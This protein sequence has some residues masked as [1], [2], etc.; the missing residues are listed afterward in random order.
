MKRPT[1]I[2]IGRVVLPAQMRGQD[3]AFEAALRDALAGHGT[4]DGDAP[5]RAAQS[6]ADAIAARSAKGWSDD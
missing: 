2:S 1:S 6:A 4:P 3:G 5:A